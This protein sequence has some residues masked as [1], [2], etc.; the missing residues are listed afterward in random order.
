L[1]DGY[2]TVNA[3]PVQTKVYNDTVDLDIRFMKARST[4]L[5]VLYLKGND[6]TNDKVVMREIRTK[7][8]PK[9]Q[10]RVIDTQCAR[11]WAAG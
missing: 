7:A 11:N 4:P 8:G 5:T 10:Q 6:V 2:L 1:N 9:I 3:D